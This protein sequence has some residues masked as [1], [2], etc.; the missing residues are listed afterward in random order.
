[1][2]APAVVWEGAEALRAQLVPVEALSPHPENP[3]RGDVAEIAKSL[4][5]FG[6]VRLVLADAAGA[7]IAGNH[8]Y[9]AAVQLGWTH[10]AALLHEFS[11]VEEAR[12][13]LL[14]DNRLGD[15]GEYERV[16]LR[17]HLEDLEKSG[18]WDGTGY[19]SDDLAH[20]RG[21]DRLA[22]EPPPAAPPALPPSAP[23]SELREMVLLFTEEQH[24]QFGEN[25]RLVRADYGLEGVTETVVRAVRD[26][27][28]RANQ[29]AA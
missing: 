27:A 18:R 1:V 3:R 4:S 6:Q 14:A 23:P 25:V 5:R 12:A 7:I 28:L 19:V 11:T 20:L 2:T 24:T 9:K 10:V 15:L 8:T 21:L 22:A 29:G 13:Y 17:L 16:E 26:E